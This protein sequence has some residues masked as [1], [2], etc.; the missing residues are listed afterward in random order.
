[1]KIITHSGN[2]HPDDVFGVAALRMVFGNDV[3]IVRTRDVNIIKNKEKDD[4]VLDIGDAYDP[5]TNCFDHHQEGGAGKREN[6]IPYASFGLVW[7]TY[8][9]RIAGSK[10]SADSIEEKLVLPIDAG[11]NG[12]DTF[13]KA[14]KHFKPYL[15]DGVL[16]SLM[17]TWEEKDG[18]IDDVFLQA[19]GIAQMVL[20]REVAKSNAFINGEAEVEKAYQE[21]ADKRIIFLDNNYSWKNVIAKHDEVLFVIMNDGKQTTWA[22]NTVP[23]DGVSFQRRKLFPQAWAGKKGKELATITGVPDAHFCHNHKFFAV[24]N[25]RE[26]AFKMAQLAVEA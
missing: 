1:M 18:N 20:E 12:I 26:G 10:R 4:I 23:T 16:I 22:I 5:E 14:N 19:V 24:A 7:K 21:A 11:D 17:P 25:S 9:E 13:Q 15:L 6:G 8:G 3:E 2:Y